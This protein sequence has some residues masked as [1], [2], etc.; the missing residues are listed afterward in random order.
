M[1]TSILKH[2][3][4]LLTSLMLL[5]GFNFLAGSQLSGSDDPAGPQLENNQSHRVNKYDKQHIYGKSDSNQYDADYFISDTP[6]SK[7]VYHKGVLI[8][9]QEKNAGT[10]NAGESGKI[11]TALRA[12]YDAAPPQEEFRI[13]VKIKGVA[14]LVFPKGISKK[15]RGKSGIGELKRAAGN[16]QVKIKSLLNKRKA[17]G[18]V[19]SLRDYWLVNMVACS[20][21]KDVVKE[22]LSM[23]EVEKIYED[24]I[25]PIP[26]TQKLNAEIPEGGI[27]DAGIWGLERI[28][29]ARMWNEGFRG[30]G[31]II[32]SIDTG[33]YPDHPSIAGK[34]ALAG[35]NL[36]GWHDSFYRSQI[37]V[38]NIGH[39]THT[40]GT[41]VGG[42]SNSEGLAIGVAPNAQYYS[43]R[44]FASGERTFEST[45]LDA[46]QWMADP[47]GNPDTDDIPEIINN[48]WG[49]SEAGSVD[50]WF[51]DMIRNWRALGIIPVFAAGNSGPV[52]RTASA[53]GNYPESF[54]VAASDITDRITNFSSRGP[55]LY[56]G[57]DIAKPDIA[58]PGAY[59]IS[60]LA[61][62]SEYAYL[63]PLMLVGT[64][65]VWLNGTSMAAPHVAG[66]CALLRQKYPDASV[67]E[68]INL[69]RSE[70][71][72]LGQDIFAQGNGRL[73]LTAIGGAT[74]VFEPRFI[75]LGRD[76]KTQAVWTIEKDINIRN[77][78][79]QPRLYT[80]SL[81]ELPD[82]INVTLTPNNFEVNAGGVETVHMVISVDN[83]IV[84]DVSEYP[85]MYKIK[86]EAHSEDQL[87]AAYVLFTKSARLILELDTACD[88]ILLIKNDGTY[89]DLLSGIG[90]GKE[91]DIPSHG[92]YSLLAM[93]N[94]YDKPTYY[95]IKENINITAD[96]VVRICR[97]E[98]NHRVTIS[99][100]DKNGSGITRTSQKYNIR[101][102]LSGISF[103]RGETGSGVISDFYYIS[104]VSS[105]FVFDFSTFA[106]VDSDFYCINGAITTG[107]MADS[108]L[109]NIPADFKHIS[110]TYNNQSAYDR[111]FIK[112]FFSTGW[113]SGHGVNEPTAPFSVNY[114]ISRDPWLDYPYKYSSD[115][116][117]DKLGW[118]VSDDYTDLL[119]QTPLISAPDADTIR[120]QRMIEGNPVIYETQEENLYFGFGPPHF[121][122][123]LE[124]SETAIRLTGI[125][126]TEDYSLFAK[127]FFCQMYEIKYLERLS[128]DIFKDGVNLGQVN[129]ELLF[130]NKMTLEIPTGSPDNAGNYSLKIPY[131]YIVAGARGNGLVTLDFNTRNPQDK[132]PPVITAF[133]IK[134]NGRIAE[135]LE[136]A[137]NNSLSFNLADESDIAEVSVFYKRSS[138][139]WISLPFQNTG[140]GYVVTMP[141]MSNG[142]V[143][144][145]VEA[146]DSHGNK[147]INEFLPAFYVGI[148]PSP[149][150]RPIVAEY[151]SPNPCSGVTWPQVS[152][153]DPDGDWIT[154]YHWFLSG[155]TQWKWQ[156]DSNTYI[157]ADQQIVFFKVRDQY[158]L[159]SEKDADVIWVNDTSGVQRPNQPDGQIG[160]PGVVHLSWGYTGEIPENV[161]G[162]R[163]YF[164]D[165]ACDLYG[166]F[167][168]KRD[169]IEIPD[170]LQQGCD[171]SLFDG[172]YRCLAGVSAITS[173][174][175]ESVMSD[176]VTIRIPPPA[177][178]HPPVLDPIGNKAIN[179]GQLLQ[180]IVT[181]SDP[182]GGVIYLSA[183][184]LPS[185]ASFSQ[186]TDTFSWRPTFQQSGVYNVIFTATDEENY[187]D[188]ESVTII[189]NDVPPPAPPHDLVATT[190]SH[191]SI[192][193]QWQHDDPASVYAFQMFRATDPNGS[194]TNLG[195]VLANAGTNV[196][197]RTCGS[198]QSNI[199][200]YF[201]VRAY[202]AGPNY[203][204]YSNIATA[205][206]DRPPLLDLIG[207]KTVNE[208]EA[209]S[210]TVTATDPDSDA[211]TYSAANLPAGANF[212]P[213]THI[214]T[215]TPTY[216]QA[217]TYQVTFTVADGAI[218]DGEVIKDE[219]TIN[220][221]VNNVDNTPPSTP[222]VL[223]GAVYMKTGNII[224]A[225][226]NS[227]DAESGIAEYQ[228]AVGT[229]IGGTNVRGWT[230]V[231]TST[232]LDIAGLPLQHMVNYYVSAKARNGAGLWSSIGTSNPISFDLTAPTKPV[233]KDDGAYTISKTTLH[234]TWSSGDPESGIIKY[235]YCIGTQIG[236]GDVVNWTSTGTATSVTRTGLT[237]QHD[238][239]YWFGVRATNKVG[240]VSE[241]GYSD[242]IIVD[243]PPVLLPIGNKTIKEGQPYTLR[244][245]ASD[246]DGE[247][248]TYSGNPL[249]KNATFYSDKGI[250]VWMPGYDQAG[251][252][253]IKFTVSDGNLSASETISI[254]VTDVI[255]PPYNLTAAAMSSSQ[256]KL[257]WIDRMPDE[258]GFVIEISTDGI[259]YTSHSKVIA[260][261]TSSII[262]AL[263][264]NTKYY[265][266][267][268][269]FKGS[270]R[271]GYS[272]V[273][274]ATTIP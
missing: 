126:G 251:S 129:E 218:I 69:L 120:V 198:L 17:E 67:D 151:L 164:S 58:A 36:P 48:S 64:D 82:G 254:T 134:S 188:S 178:P 242:G 124:N 88:Y 35:N 235:E 219:E 155:A 106:K 89:S 103:G 12:K 80:L 68:I 74:T 186:K 32:G 258:T 91:I 90:T 250:F 7:D 165:N 70:A 152:A 97:S 45:I 194:W 144:L 52:L 255:L 3:I 206:T 248:L 95:V 44:I 261:T 269:T 224:R 34:M 245:A 143:D 209:L 25:V 173:D 20:V 71:Y 109:E 153:S 39:G 112:D 98:A 230:S 202:T 274:S 225:K 232:N 140:N 260:N 24:K 29:A 111:L 182:A 11:E 223:G 27:S 211:L 166:D 174:D 61:P 184:N 216:E 2:N 130:S 63:D 226:W 249:P 15:E 113:Y 114:Y 148:N 227:S 133:Q 43:A 92:L 18:K 8:D 177:P 132:N 190:K 47:D 270:S 5:L 172:Q 187:S 37:P 65:L 50:E 72:D 31:V 268:F 234:A 154:D 199:R 213:G 159:W 146:S 262:A 273:A 96:T 49:D 94:L 161:V 33:V 123:R 128:V 78:S 170:R 229:T 136:P 13:L 215:W 162:Y 116:K 77:L 207:D 9:R 192:D 55:A 222:I 145:K 253:S 79:E 157:S 200:Y 150:R 237:L 197:T 38:D 105:D 118:I 205:I 238:Q 233:V 21:S 46:A 191:S 264:P 101:H 244:L 179:E 83:G 93:F 236:G 56:D 26:K 243:A 19:K 87:E 102:S 163:V 76:D 41:M 185:G 125:R 139:G 167:R 110:I 51:R 257:S 267:M 122:G 160:A 108:V 171:I 28:D 66:A 115:V 57:V 263:K 75:Y 195:T 240:L 158:G 53:P 121:G 85:H 241:T 119:F 6:E 100:Y 204:E 131:L 212:D 1:K 42:D 81:P 176:I 220:I 127:L 30:D 86:I 40:I 107:V 210:F 203:S 180:F 104:D 272:N 231:G 147:I 54:C 193:I 266:R 239:R 259:T 228:Y 84:P 135:S 60:A 208:M 168:S 73:N 169:Y 23:P 14:N 183:Q 246:P 256:I 137:G 138:G 175:K 265:F 142:P 141:S 217:G 62:G 221:T 117:L 4:I 149:N 196:Y 214:F 16:S 201:K 99:A 189:V 22:I 10:L 252:Y 59:I 156:N 247:V 181:A 271:S